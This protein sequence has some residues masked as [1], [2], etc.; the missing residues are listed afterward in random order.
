MGTKV[1]ATG[2]EAYKIQR[3]NGSR[4]G[5]IANTPNTYGTNTRPNGRLVGTI[6][7]NI[8]DKNTVQNVR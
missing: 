3:E 8:W 2:T 6:A 7:T 1:A 4:L 5:T